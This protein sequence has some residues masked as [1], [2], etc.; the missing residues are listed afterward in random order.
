[1]HHEASRLSGSS[2]RPCGKLWALG[3]A[4]LPGKSGGVSPPKGWKALTKGSRS[5]QKGRCLGGALEGKGK[6]DQ[7]TPPVSAVG[8]S[9]SLKPPVP[10]RHKE[11]TAKG[12]VHYARSGIQSFDVFSCRFLDTSIEMK[13][14]STTTFSSFAF[15]NHPVPWVLCSSA[16]WYWWLLKEHRRRNIKWHWGGDFPVR[17]VVKTLPSNGGGEGLIPDWGAKIPH[18]LWP[19]N[20]NIIWKQNYNKFDKGF[21]NGPCKKKSLKKNDTNLSTGLWK[22]KSLSAGMMGCDEGRAVL[23]TRVTPVGAQAAFFNCVIAITF[24]LS[25]RATLS[26]PSLWLG[27]KSDDSIFWDLK[28]TQHH[29]EYFMCS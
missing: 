17:P 29:S 7:D 24:F 22:W 9:E 25:W 4:H 26:P 18:A 5:W 2:L 27:A 8:L 6:G 3:L 1:M 16:S 10:V 21:K 28:G 15:K 19:K 12:H 14:S 20:Q 13:L 23:M 11:P